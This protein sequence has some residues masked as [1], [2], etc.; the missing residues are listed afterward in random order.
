MH[1]AVAEVKK[2]CVWVLYWFVG[3]SCWSCAVFG[4][5]CLAVSAACSVLVTFPRRAWEGGV[6]DAEM[7]FADLLVAAL[8][9]DWWHSFGCFV[10]G[11]LFVLSFYGG[12]EMADCD[13][14]RR[15]VESRLEP[16]RQSQTVEMFKGHTACVVCLEKPPTITLVPCGH[17]ILC[18][19]CF[20]LLKDGS[21]CPLCKFPFVSK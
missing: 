7:V 15:A 16:S 10:V 9:L 3:M 2:I 6:C 4:K 12:C 1:E 21:V 20:Q 8:C 11:S 14:M 13:R 5:Y 19:S 17:S 18:D